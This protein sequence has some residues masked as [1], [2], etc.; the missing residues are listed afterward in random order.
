MLKK[1]MQIIALI[2]TLTFIGCED[3]PVSSTDELT[4]D[5]INDEFPEAQQEVMQVFG[6]IAQ[7]IKNGDMDK[8]IQVVVNL[9][10]NAVMEEKQ[11]KLMNAVFL[12]L[13][14]K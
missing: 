8:L 1:T 3:D 4:V 12:V 2:L 9:L 7:S 13:L 6:E 10:S 11:M 5:L 14:R